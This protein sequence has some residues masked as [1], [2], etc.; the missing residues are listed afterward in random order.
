MDNA[1]LGKL[2]NAAATGSRNAKAMIYTELCNE[3]PKGQAKQLCQRLIAERRR[4]MAKHNVA[5]V[6][7]GM[8]GGGKTAEL[9]KYIQENINKSYTYAEIVDWLHLG[10]PEKT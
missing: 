2:I 4:E 9:K 10:Q 3:Y 1:T 6:F 5:I 7:A 8:S